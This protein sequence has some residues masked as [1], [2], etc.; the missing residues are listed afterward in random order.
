M[1]SGELTQHR[2]NFSL[3]KR[4]SVTSLSLNRLFSYLRINKSVLS[5]FLFLLFFSFLF[6]MKR[7]PVRSFV[8]VFFFFSVSQSKPEVTRENYGGGG[9]SQSSFPCPL[10]HRFLV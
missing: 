5:S 7:K 10:S 1:V 2:R 3:R 9:E 6:I 8:F 4:F